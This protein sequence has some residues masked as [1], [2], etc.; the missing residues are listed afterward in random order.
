VVLKRLRFYSDS[1]FVQCEQE[2][3]REILL[4]QAKFLGHSQYQTLNASVFVADDDHVREFVLDVRVEED[5]TP[6]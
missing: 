5:V 1:S 6:S 4:D 3:T 2:S